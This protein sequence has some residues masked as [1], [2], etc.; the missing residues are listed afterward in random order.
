M[1]NHALIQVAQTQETAVQLI[2]EDGYGFRYAYARSTESR[3][4][5]DVGQDY[6]AILQQPGSLA[7]ALC[8]GVGQSF[9]GNLAAKFLGD[10]LVDWLMSLSPERLSSPELAGELSLYLDSLKNEAAGMVQQYPLPENIPP[11]LQQVL[12]KKR[13]MGSESTLVA[14]RIEFS[15]D[16]VLL[17]W[18][19]DSRLRIWDQQEETTQILGDT[20]LT[21]ERWSTRRGPVG[22]V[23][24][25]CGLPAQVKRLTAYSDGL[26]VLDNRLKGTPPGNGTVNRII[27]EVSQD[28]ASDDIS[29]FEFW[30]GPA[31]FTEKSPGAVTGLQLITT[32][33]GTRLTWSPVPQAGMYEVETLDT[34]ERRVIQKTEHQWMELPPDPVAARIVS[35]RVRAV[36]GENV[37][38]WSE[39]FRWIYPPA[40]IHPEAKRNDVFPMEDSQPVPVE[41]L[42]PEHIPSGTS[43][44]LPARRKRIW[45]IILLLLAVLLA[46]ICVITSI[47]RNGEE[48]QNQSATQTPVVLTATSLKS[49]DSLILPMETSTPTFTQTPSSSLLPT[50]IIGQPDLRQTGTP[51]KP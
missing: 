48:R 10:A 39:P 40:E 5:G 24:V 28:L 25:F 23:H 44:K 50:V 34:S 37:G 47:R 8:D 4:G 2:Q 14:G 33:T 46:V 27:T 49:N 17:I 1:K 11:M 38:E 13:S 21:A 20:F 9:Y 45:R 3:N 36:E 26:A 15:T 41:R 31:P 32:P 42:E 43:G 30:F 12:E 16:T 19:G 22:T 35:V 7:F 29:Y 18:M 6:L 51:P